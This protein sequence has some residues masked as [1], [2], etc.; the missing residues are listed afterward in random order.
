MKKYV[1]KLLCLVTP[2]F[3]PP[4]TVEVRGKKLT[5]DNDD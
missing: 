2:V 4:Y 3:Y 1:F 5:V